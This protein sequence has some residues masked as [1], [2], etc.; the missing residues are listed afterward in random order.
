MSKQIIVKEWSEV[1]S[2]DVINL[3][4]NNEGSLYVEIGW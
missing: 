3:E 4:I 1:G 2:G